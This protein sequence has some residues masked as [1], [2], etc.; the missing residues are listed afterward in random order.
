MNGWTEVE[1]AGW[2]L[3]CCDALSEIGAIRHGVT[4]RRGNL[5]LSLR[6]AQNVDTAIRNRSLVAA[7]FDAAI[8]SLVIP[9]QVHGNRVAVV[10]SSANGSAISLPGEADALVTQVPGAL[11]G[12]TVAD[13]LP[14]LLYDS[15]N[16]AVGLA[17]SGWRGTAGRIVPNTLNAM[18]NEFGTDPRHVVAAVGPGI[19]GRCYE[20][21]D[22]VREAL[23]A[24]NAPRDSLRPSQNGRWML[25]LTTIVECQARE[26]GIRESALSV[27]PCCTACH[28]HLFYSHRKEG[29]M[30]GRFGAFI[31]LD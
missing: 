19:C 20:V 17:H 31:R 6:T 8:D 16:H 5:N 27:A 12:I 14:V 22:E 18:Q 15:E 25:D 11:L 1:S 23:L 13:C 28:N 30:A 26:S 10:K 24:V 4:T 7:H 9:N 2:S 3:V 21:G 29:A